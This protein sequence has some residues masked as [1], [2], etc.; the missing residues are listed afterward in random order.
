MSLAKNRAKLEGSVSRVIDKEILFEFVLNHGL[1]LS[2]HESLRASE[3]EMGLGFYLV[4][5][6]NRPQFSWMEL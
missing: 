5:P 4:P 1:I 2:Y 6:P 3:L